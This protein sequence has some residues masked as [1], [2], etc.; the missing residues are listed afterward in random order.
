[1]SE[2]VGFINDV[3]SRA[4]NMVS[5]GTIPANLNTGETNKATIMQWIMDERLRE[6][7]AEGGRWWDLRRWA[8]GGIIT[9]NNATT[10]C[11]TP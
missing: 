9:L 10:Y 6:L 1:M 4:R 3:R 11:P 7:G 8:I 2:A 5:G